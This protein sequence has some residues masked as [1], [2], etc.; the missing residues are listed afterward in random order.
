M[1]GETGD[2]NRAILQP[3]DICHTHLGE[4]VE[5]PGYSQMQVTVGINKDHAMP[6]VAMLEPSTPF[7]EHMVCWWQGQF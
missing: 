1:D 2:K 4:S 5:V 7:M 3:H 6:G